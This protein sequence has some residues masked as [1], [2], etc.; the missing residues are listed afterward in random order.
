[1]KCVPG[2]CSLLLLSFF[3]PSCGRAQTSPFPGGAVVD[4]S[5]AF[6]AETVYW[7]TAEPFKLEK[8]FEG[9]TEGGYFYAANRFST[10]EHGGT[11]IDAP[12]HFAEGRNTVER[13]PLE[14]LIGAGIVIDVAGACERDA[15]YQVSVQD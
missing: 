2:V 3:T 9:M 8:D 5:H 12:V 4:L 13:I 15:D 6:D 14:Q 7:P 10:A 11:H 1:M